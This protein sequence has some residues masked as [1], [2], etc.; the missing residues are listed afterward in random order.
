MNKDEV[1]AKYG[2]VPMTFTS[3][4]KYSFSFAGQSEDGTFVSCS[5]GGDS[6]EIYRF[7]VTPDTTMFL[8]DGEWNYA[9][10]TKD[11]NELWCEHNW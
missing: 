6:D 10:I 3:Y 2:D 11:G 7:E 9:S 5:F 8:K 4:Y 1:M